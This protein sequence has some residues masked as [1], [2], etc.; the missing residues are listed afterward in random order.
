M[1]AQ[2]IENPSPNPLELVQIRQ[3]RVA[4]V[5]QALR[6]GARWY[7]FQDCNGANTDLFDSKYV[8]DIRKAVVICEIECPVKAQCLQEAYTINDTGNNIR[9]GLNSSQRKLEYKKMRKQDEMTKARAKR[10]QDKKT[11]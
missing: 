11:A 3:E 7:E 1:S 4:F 6:E 9:A 10:E 2:S 8:S 5:A